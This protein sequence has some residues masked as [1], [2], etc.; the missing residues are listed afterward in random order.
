MDCSQAGRS[1]HPESPGSPSLGSCAMVVEG[2]GPTEQHFDI[3]AD[4]EALA[5]VYQGVSLD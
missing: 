2:T 3:A 4:W 5:D 1:K